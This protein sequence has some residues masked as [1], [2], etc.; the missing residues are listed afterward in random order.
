MLVNIRN[1]FKFNSIAKKIAVMASVLTGIPVIA[2]TWLA[3][4]QSQQ[5]L[6]KVAAQD[7]HH[8]ASSLLE[9]CK[10]Q[11]ELMNAKLRSDIGVAEALLGS[12]AEGW[13]KRVSIGAET[14][15]IGT[16][17][18][19]VAQ[20]G[21]VKLTGNNDLPDQVT[22]LTGSTCTVF[23]VVGNRWVRVATSIRK[24]D[25]SRAVGTTIESDSPVFK[26]VM[27]G[28]T[29]IGTNEIL[30]KL[31]ET[32]YRPLWDEAGNV[33]AVLYVGV[34]HNEFH[35]LK[36]AVGS[37]KLGETGYAYVM[38]GDGVLVIHPSKV[39]ADLSKY[40]FAQ[41][42]KKNKR[43]W[44]EYVWEGRLKFTAYEYFEP[45]DWIIA[46]GAYAD[47]YNAAATS[48]RNRMTAAALVFVVL[49]AILAVILGNKIAY[50]VRR[51]TDAIREIAQ[52]D[53]DLTQRLRIRST[54]ETGRLAEE[55]NT[56]VSK[57]HDLIVDVA[58]ATREVAGASTQIAASSEEMA[59][60]MQQQSDQA[61]QVSSAVEEMTASVTEVA[62][63]SAEAA[64]S[65]KDAG[66]QAQTG[67]EVVDQSVE[68]MKEI[69]Q[70]VNESAGAIN[71]LGKRGEQIGQIIGVINDIADQTN[72]L[73]LNAAIEA[74]RAGEHGR[75]FAV[76]ADEVRKLADR[77]TKATEEIAESINAI[78]QETEL[79][80]NRMN[81]GT[82]RVEAGVELAEKAGQSLDQIVNSAS[83]VASMIESIAA[84][85]EQQS[86][87]AEQISRSVQSINAVSNEAA[88]GANQAAT[89][90]AQLSNKAEQ[91]QALVAQFKI[92][93]AQKQA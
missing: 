67:G 89:A 85:S 61:T 35:A 51:V 74:A 39:G 28:K 25:G 90:A 24:D 45:Y 5:A 58:D 80:V 52:G 23:Q 36:A 81:A 9:T 29:Y 37:I 57:I 69:A 19:P 20:I 83:S 63:K 13:D 18:V 76:V 30:G 87:A 27:S 26:T 73:A 17:D 92:D 79:A 10:T 68:G 1:I 77:T 70:V 41:E 33:Q 91:L 82:Q 50:G 8:V 32:V 3:V 56:F 43:G 65:A 47:E 46:A 22:K 34:P 66:I 71:E 14:E 64:Q 75:G 12:G 15:R 86:A 78:Q 40:D 55:F 53:G 7:L 48:I 60:G 21:N 59:A 93:P 4:T 6:D 54:D 49:A 31:Y 62:R 44:V 42:M 84:A 72:L 38:R 16:Y 2:V 11:D 88:Q